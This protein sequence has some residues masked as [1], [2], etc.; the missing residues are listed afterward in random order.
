MNLVVSVATNQEVGEATALFHQVYQDEFELDFDRFERAFP[1]HFPSEV[2]LIRTEDGELVGTASFM[3]PVDGMFPSEYI[4]GAKI[5]QQAHLFPFEQTVEIGRLAKR[6][7][8]PSGLIAKTVMLATDAYLKFYNMQAWIA[9]V[10]PPLY[11][12]LAKTGLE[13]VPFELGPEKTGEQGDCV[14]RYKGGSIAIF[15]ASAESTEDAFLPIRYSMS[16]HTVRIV[17]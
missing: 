7:N 10:K 11:Q 13:M 3:K 17:L 14:R 1:M 6:R 8:F 15:R 4:F 9:T 12:M 2:L 16:E 5:S